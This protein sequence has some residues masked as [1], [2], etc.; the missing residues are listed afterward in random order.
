[1]SARGC[2]GLL[3]PLLLLVLGAC[4]EEPDSGGEFADPPESRDQRE[5]ATAPQ[6]RGPD[7]TPSPQVS[8]PRTARIG[9]WSIPKPDWPLTVSEGV[10]RCQE[11]AGR[12]VVTFVTPDARV[13]GVNGAAVSRGLPRID[14]I[15][16]RDP[17]LPGGRAD[18]SPLLEQGLRLCD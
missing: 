8:S 15:W 17:D 13:Y 11:R 18:I 16:R 14:P 12:P 4:G 6:P 5:Q 10:V 2:T 7:L 3:V 9:T 1:M